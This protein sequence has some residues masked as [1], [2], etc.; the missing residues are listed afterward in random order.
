MTLT[1]AEAR[2]KWCPFSRYSVGGDTHGNRWKQSL[3]E[4]EPHALNPVPC[5]CIGSDCMAWRR[6]HEFA[7]LPVG[8]APL[9]DGWVKDGP[10]RGAGGAVTHRQTWKRPVGFCGMAGRPTEA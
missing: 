5:R 2:T 6:T 10:P 9:G 8:M 7:D 4:D 1:E 3:P